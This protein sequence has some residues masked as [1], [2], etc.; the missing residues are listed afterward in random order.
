MTAADDADSQAR[1]AAELAAF[2]GLEA[3]VLDG[4]AYRAAGGASVDAD[5]F[6]AQAAAADRD[7]LAL[8]PGGGGAVVAATEAA[9]IREA[10][11]RA[12]PARRVN[13]LR[14]NAA[15][16]A[17]A[18]IADVRAAA[19]LLCRSQSITGQLIALG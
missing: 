18:R 11:R 7:V 8:L 4:A 14:V 19:T 3:L 6:L 12:A 9:M 17:P 13:A 16:A 2:V 5:A 1:L 10:A 15:G